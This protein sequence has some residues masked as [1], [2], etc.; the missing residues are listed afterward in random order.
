MAGGDDGVE[1]ILEE[2]EGLLVA[3][4]HADGLDHRVAL[5]VDAGLD[6]VGEGDAEGGLLVLELGPELGLLLQHV[7]D[8]VVVLVSNDGLDVLGLVGG[9]EVG[10][11]LLA[12]VDLKFF[13]TNELVFKYFYEYNFSVPSTTLRILP[14]AK[15]FVKDCERS[16]N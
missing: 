14:P 4:D 16:R 12:D 6:A 7:A 10:S 1:E 15:R 5:V 3:A 11:L 9:V 2:G 13:R 8:E